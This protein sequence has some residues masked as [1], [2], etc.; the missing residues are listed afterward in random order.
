MDGIF[1]EYENEN[2][3]RIYPFAAGCVPPARPENEI[4]IG[5]FV[6]AALYPVNATGILYLSSVSEDGVFNISDDRGVLMMGRV[7]GKKVEFYDTTPLARHVGT[8]IASS[9]EALVE[10]AGRGELRE[11]VNTETKFAAS[12]VLPV[13]IDGVTSVSVGESS[14]IPGKLEFSNGA[15]DDVRVSS[16]TMDGRK[17]LRFDVLP[18]PAVSDDFSIRRIICVVDGQTPFRI[19]KLSP[20][21]ILLTLEGIDRDTVCSAVHRENQFEMA[22][23]CDCEGEPCDKPD[24]DVATLPE[25]YQ[26]EEVFIPPDPDGS[27]GGLVDGM[28][29][30]FYLSVPNISGYRN[31]ISITLEDGVPIPDVNG[32]QVIMDGL[33]A[34]LADGA[35]LDEI[36]SKGVVIQVPGLSG[37]EI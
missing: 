21:T 22:D 5:L 30:A 25:T 17:T 26:L 23:T 3:L 29:N 34:E 10:F 35:L 8:L 11:Y 2:A 37:G 1:L 15:N 13:V 32:P 6:D 27:E 33:N 14:L 31:P 19:E 4:P 28:D 16:G 24:A 7:S 36:S 12:C 18:R 9:E 20:N